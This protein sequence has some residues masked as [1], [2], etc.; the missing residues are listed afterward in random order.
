MTPNS[1]FGSHARD[2]TAPNL[3]S[4]EKISAVGAEC[5]VSAANE[6]FWDTEDPSDTH[7]EGTVQPYNAFDVEGPLDAKS[8]VRRIDKHLLPLLFSL[9]LL[10]SVDRAN[11]SYAALQLNDDLQFSHS[12]YGFGSGLF[13]IGYMVLQIPSTYLCSRVGPPR[14]LGGIL[15]VWGIVA[16]LFAWMQTAMHFYVLRFILGLAESGAYPGMW[17]SMALFY[18]SGELGPAYATVAMATAVASVLGGPIAACLLM[19]NGVAGL[20][21][22]QWLFLLEGTPAVVLGFVICWRLPQDPEHSAFLT[23]AEQQ[24]CLDRRKRSGQQEG[25]APEAPGKLVATE[26]PQFYRSWHIWYVGA[27]WTLVV[28]G[29]DGIVFWGPILIHSFTDSDSGT[30]TQAAEDLPEDLQEGSL[31]RA[32]AQAALLSAIPFGIASIGMLV[33]AR[34]AKSANDRHW[35]G[36]VPVLIGAVALAVMPVFMSRVAWAAFTCLSIGA[37]G[38]W[39]VHGP[40]MS[41]PAVILSGTNAA[42]GFALMKMMG[43]AGSFVGPFFIGVTS[44]AFGS[45][46]PAMLMLAACLLGAAAMQLLYREPGA[47]R[48][49]LPPFP[50]A[51]TSMRLMKRSRSDTREVV[52]GPTLRGILGSRAFRWE[53]VDAEAQQAQHAESQ[54]QRRPAQEDTAHLLGEGLWERHTELRGL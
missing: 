28:T 21:G 1:G 30:G 7:K 33:V 49:W 19:L 48:G 40:L 10:C 37:F 54:A 29:M 20:H 31:L 2:A 32:T 27:V 43:S 52:M 5:T 38:I 12:V 25:E 22:W 51:C 39:A 15:I 46:T 26:E 35:H 13:F 34:M 47:T 9:A 3:K 17:Y 45:F 14:F 6:A 50:Y 18:D 44:D 23:P 16:S 41:W 4:L 42:S 36:A 11:L 24:W 8:I 53:R